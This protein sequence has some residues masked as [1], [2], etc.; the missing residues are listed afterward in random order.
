MI[1][2]IIAHIDMNSYFA[3]VEQQANP[4]L[5][6]K[7]IGVAGRPDGR[8]VC[9]AASIEAKKFGLKSGMSI[10]EAKTLCPNIIIVTADPEKYTYLTRK[11]LNIFYRYTPEV[12]PFSIDESFLD[13][14]HF[15]SWNRAEDI[16]KKIKED[17]RRELGEWISCSI[18]IAQN[19]LIAK[20]ASDKKKPDGLVVVRPENLREVI[21]DSKL[22]DF[23]GV[24]PRTEK[25]LN[26]SGIFTTKSLHR[27]TPEFLIKR[28]GKVRGF[29]LYNM[30]RGYASASSRLDG[31]DSSWSSQTQTTRQKSMSHSYTLPRDCNRSEI[32]YSYIVRLVED[33]GRRLRSEGYMARKIGLSLRS[34]DLGWDSKGVALKNYTWQT[35]EILGVVRSIFL[36]IT[37]RRV[38]AVRAVGV[39]LTGLEK[40]KFLPDF[41]LLEEKKLERSAKAEDLIISKFGKEAIFR[42]IGARAQLSRHIGG[43][44]DNE[45]YKKYSRA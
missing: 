2:Q 11:F 29:F 20:L 5:R 27:A 28:F 39:W 4:A 6:G 15:E 14:S 43:F 19:R 13:L 1:H 12:L 42:G 34:S 31:I 44:Y 25:A 30:V 21:F 3:T 17:I 35:G 24:G 38:Y 7:P 33:L 37:N 41:L 36:Q 8:S 16:C 40:S 18:G 23:C 22:S 26:D 10:P 45:K 32:T 9:A